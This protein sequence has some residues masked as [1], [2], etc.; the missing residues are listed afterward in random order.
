MQKSNPS[1]YPMWNRIRPLHTQTKDIRKI[2]PRIFIGYSQD[3]QSGSLI[4]KK[5]I[6]PQAFIHPEVEIYTPMG[7]L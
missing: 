2:F 5:Y 3:I 1:D 7:K 4:K 6:I